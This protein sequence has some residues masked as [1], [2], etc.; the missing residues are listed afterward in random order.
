FPYDWRTSNAEKV[1]RLDELV[2]CIRAIHPGR[3][4]NVLAHSMGGLLARRYVVER[5]GRISKVVTIGS[6]FV[7]APKVLNTLGTG[8]F[9][10]FAQRLIIKSATLKRLAEFFPG[11]HELMPSRAYVERLGHRPF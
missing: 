8:Q 5:P 11:A 10:G 4:I 9:L 2:E 3:R 7:G 1:E 6:P